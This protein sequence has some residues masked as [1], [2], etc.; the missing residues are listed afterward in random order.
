MSLLGGPTSGDPF[1]QVKREA[2]AGD[3]K[4]PGNRNHP[5]RAR[6]PEQPPVYPLRSP[7]TQIW[8]VW[9]QAEPAKHVAIGNLSKSGFIWEGR[10]AR[11]HW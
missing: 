5:Q 11:G 8:I 9:A 2:G 6:C 7:V 3:G 10:Q 4:L 1:P